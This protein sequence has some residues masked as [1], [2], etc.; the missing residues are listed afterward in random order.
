MVCFDPFLQGFEGLQTGRQIG[1][2][3][4]L[5][6]HRGLCHLALTIQFGQGRFQVQ[7]RRLG[8]FGLGLGLLHRSACL[9]DLLQVGQGQG[10][11]VVIE[12]LA[13]QLHLAALIFDVALIGRQDLYLLLHLHHLQALLIGRVLRLAHRV[14]QLG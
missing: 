5:G 14:F 11:F 7:Q 10:A 9:F 13:A 4:R 8:L 3:G 12:P 1:L 2:A 6:V